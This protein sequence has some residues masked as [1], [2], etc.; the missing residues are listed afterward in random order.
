MQGSLYGVGLRKVQLYISTYS[1][2]ISST[3]EP[4]LWD[5]YARLLCVGKHSNV[6]E[7][8]QAEQDELLNV[9]LS[10]YV[11]YVSQK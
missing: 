6:A 2:C 7:K 11:I 4:S 10:A 9:I 3:A 5:H 1:V 8:L